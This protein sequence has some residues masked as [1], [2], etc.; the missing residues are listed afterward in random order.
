ML[1]DS[2]RATQPI[3]A[4]IKDA[5]QLD[6]VFDEITYEKGAAVLYMLEGFLGQD[7]FRDG[8]RKYLAGHELGNATPENLWTAL[9]STSGRNVSDLMHSWVYLKGFPQVTVDSS[10]P[11]AMLSQKRFVFLN[12]STD[13]S[14]TKDAKDSKASTNSSVSSAWQIPLQVRSL[15]DK[16]LNSSQKILFTE[17]TGKLGTNKKEPFLVD[18]K[19]EGYFRVLYSPNDLKEIMTHLG[20]M[21]V[22]ERASVLSDQFYLALSG[23]I[24]VKQY[25]EF[26]AYYRNEEDPN[27][28]SVI[29][30]QFNEMNL[31]V[32]DN[33]RA[34][35]AAFVRDRLAH[36]KKLFGWSAVE[37]QS[38]LV[39]RERA[40]VLLTLGTLGQDKDII[41]QARKLANEY[42]T[43]D[44]ASAV[45]SELFEPM[46]RIVA[47]NGNRED[48]GKLESLWQRSKTPER[49]NSA[50]M[51]LSMF[52]EP[53]LIEKTLKMSLTSK[54]ERQD[55]PLLVAAV[56]E[57][58]AGRGMAWEFVRKHIIRIAWRFP[59]HLM[60]NLV[61]AMNAL[62]T[63][64][65]LDE[66]RDFFKKHPVPSQA[67]G[68]NKII[69]AI[70]IRVEFRRHNDLA[71]ILQSLE[72]ASTK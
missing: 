34:P 16:D 14:D 72:V 50:L 13:A 25:L 24:P 1:S 56:M 53:D 31:L 15:V 43:H 21:T 71:K 65:Q 64:Q 68:I 23:Q 32:D 18:A 47:Y 62:D 70:E 6:Q 10:K 37:D 52:Q 7:I 26:T 69:E 63:Q 54:V 17:R 46:L 11:A 49:K 42:F 61:M 40:T 19:G 35:F 57:E 51:A 12:E 20:D 30:N 48:F 28:T 36:A 3:H 55:A 33:A 5:D 38:D 45:E 4:E 29:C 44:D 58:T 41:A 60:L 39:K 67:R 27:V 59:E 9:S 22:L 8:I 2:L 66:V